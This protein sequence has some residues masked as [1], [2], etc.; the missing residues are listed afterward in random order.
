MVS[1]R[2]GTLPGLGVGAMGC[3]ARAAEKT[4]RIKIETIACRVFIMISCSFV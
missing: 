4:V 2:D 3:W 1:V